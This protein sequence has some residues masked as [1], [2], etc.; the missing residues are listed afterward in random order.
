[1]SVAAANERL[2]ELG[3]LDELVRQIDRLCDAG[4]WDGLLDLRSRSRAALARGK[5]LWPVASLAEYRLALDAPGEFA[6]PV[7]EP[8]AGHM[9]LG[10]LAEVAA[11]THTWA[12]LAPAIPPGPLVTITAHERVVR[13]EDLTGDDRVDARVLD[14]PPALC[15]WEPSYPLAEY[16]AATARFPP[17]SL[18]ERRA[19][20]LTGRGARVDDA[21]ATEALLDLA[22]VWVSESN[23][24]AESIAVE[25]SALEAI[26]A[27][28][29]PR[30]RVA[31]LSPADALAWMA[32]VGASGGAH[33]RRRGMAAGRFGAWWALAALGGVTDEWP[34]APADLT[35][36]SGEL[37]WF[38]WDAWEPDTG[39]RFHLAVE[40]PVEGLAWVVAAT[41]AA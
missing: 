33:G 13:G 10:P 41:D 36:L 23:G 32:W 15:D 31:E 14:L 30:A 26:A 9:A 29:P 20:R 5:Q 38:S 7:I 18:P 27:L 24:R 22:R 25:G 39:W 19:V 3:D 11:A 35:A 28:G 8:G 37:R 2:V 21:I 16:E 40:D 12:E 4:E 6:G 17:P 34:V 1:M